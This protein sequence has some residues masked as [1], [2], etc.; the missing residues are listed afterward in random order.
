VTIPEHEQL[1]TWTVLVPDLK[2]GVY[3]I[4]ETDTGDLSLKAVTGGNGDGS[5]GNK[6][7]TVTVVAG[8]NEESELEAAAQVVYTNN[9]DVVEINATKTWKDGAESVNDKITNTS[10]TF[11]LQSRIADTGTWTKV[12]QTGVENPKIMKVE[13]TANASAWAVTWSNLP[14]YQR[15]TGVNGENQVEIRYR[16]LE[17]AATWNNMQLLAQD[18]AQDEAKAAEVS[19]GTCNIDNPL[20]R[21]DVPVAKVWKDVDGN[22]L[23][24]W[25]KDT[26]VTLGLVRRVGTE[27]WSDVEEEYVEQEHTLTRQKAVTL[28]ADHT[29]DSFRDLP[30]YDMHGIAYEYDVV[31]TSVTIGNTTYSATTDIKPADLFSMTTDKSADVLTV[32]NTLKDIRLDIVKV[33]KNNTTKKL[34]GAKFKLTRKLAGEYEYR[35]FD[36]TAFV[37][38]ELLKA[39]VFTVDESTTISKL[40]PGDYQLTEMKAPD[41]YII[42]TGD[43]SF[44]INADGTVTYPAQGTTGNDLV[45]LTKQK[46]KTEAETGTEA[47]TFTVAELTVQNE[48]GA[49]LPATG[50]EGM[51]LYYVLGTLLTL[52]AVALLVAKR[53]RDY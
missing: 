16:V 49:R 14:K 41:G 15:I 19:N 9:K 3:T 52:A 18:D 47:A 5:V 44:T 12:E 48:P 29:K 2:P 17:T 30:Q 39:K 4:T 36:N 31:E 34:S 33:E 53:R 40:L 11:E 20:P 45:T 28:T 1:G 22:A 46:T 25:P 8:K 10:A 50:G 6:T 51:G 21:I 43:I 26:N 37:N 38:D 35:A 23:A 42:M 32:Y 13:D 27:A 7:V 24:G